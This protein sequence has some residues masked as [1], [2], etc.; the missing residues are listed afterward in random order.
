MKNLLVYLNPREGFDEET[1][2]TAKIQIDNSLDLGWKREDIMMVTNF[3]YEY[4]GV[5]AVVIDGSAC[6][7][8]RL[9]STKTTAIHYLF[10][11]KM[12]GD[13]LYWVH[14][15]DAFQSVPITEDEIDLGTKDM[16]LSDYGRL[17]KWSTG[18]I[19]FKKTAADI[20]K[21]S[22][23]TIYRRRTDEERS[24]HRLTENN[25]D[26]RSRV[27]KMNLS[28]NFQINNLKL[29]YPEALKPLRVVHFHPTEVKQQRTNALDFFI[30]GK[31]EINEVLISERLKK[32]FAKYGIT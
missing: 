18:S 27:K 19:F 3:D 12:I 31:N 13:G 5:R 1:Q 24:L 16:G 29:Y 10:E 25:E 32:I 17:P 11:H 9:H 4:N 30:R 22:K 21:L 26:I 14:D 8:I 20:F 23:E 7:E 2:M 15:F 6:C 28:Y